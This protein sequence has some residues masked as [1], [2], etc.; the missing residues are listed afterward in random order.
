MSF[1]RVL[2][3]SPPWIVFSVLPFKTPQKS[4]LE[5]T[6]MMIEIVDRI[7]PFADIITF[8]VGLPA[9][10]GT[11]YQA[12][13]TRQEARREREGRLHSQDCL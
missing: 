4:T 8:V 11:Y 3:N 9:V 13:K 5:K 6:Q 7:A 12:L 2:C 10:L 1:S